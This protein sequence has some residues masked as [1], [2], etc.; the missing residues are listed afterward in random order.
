M[1]VFRFQSEI[2][3]VVTITSIKKLSEQG[4]RAVAVDA[5]YIIGK[6]LDNK[7]SPEN[8]NI[9]IKN[10]YIDIFINNN[11]N[12]YFVFSGKPVKQLEI[13][14]KSRIN[15]ILKLKKNVFKAHLNQKFKKIQEEFLEFLW[16][17]VEN[18]FNNNPLSND[19]PFY[20]VYNEIFIEK[21]PSNILNKDTYS[22]YMTKL[23]NYVWE[24]ND[25]LF[26]LFEKF[27]INL[28]PIT[29]D[30]IDSLPYSIL[31]KIAYKHWNGKMSQKRLETHIYNVKQYLQN[32]VPVVESTYDSDDQLVTMV[33]LGIVDAIV[34]GDS[35]FFAYNTNIVIVDIDKIKEKVTYVKISDLNNNFKLNGYTKNMIKNAMIISSAD[36]NYYLCKKKIPFNIALEATIDNNGN[37]RN[38]YE[39]FY[40][41]CKK[42]NLKYNYE[43]AEE[44]SKAYNFSTL[45][46]DIKDSLHVIIKSISKF[47]SFEK[48][49]KFNHIYF[50]LIE[51]LLFIINNNIFNIK[52]IKSHVNRLKENIFF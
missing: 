39:L 45:E 24:K 41:F 38:Y 30:I 46:D 27:I 31:W 44:I 19:D 15:D 5:E 9:D 50:N 4:V 10:M 43:I 14:N 22:Y 28:E 7:K 25:I 40:Y 21:K 1:G 36:Y 29:Y 8:L 33:E 23:G 35:D 42:E 52:I 2:N 17:I 11:I 32:I 48:T 18:Y 6:L 49:K 20:N 3:N 12:V 13:I 16:D 51:I 34:S 37:I 47:I 26:K